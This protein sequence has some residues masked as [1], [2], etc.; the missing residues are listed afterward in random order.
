MTSLS[1]VTKDLKESL[2]VSCLRGHEAPV[3][4]AIFDPRGRYLATTSCD[5]SMRV[6][7]LENGNVRTQELNTVL[8][9]GP[10]VQ[11]CVKQL[12]VLHKCNDV[13]LAKSLATV[14]WQPPHGKVHREAIAM[15]LNL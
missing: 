15:L 10:C 1:K 7:D 9:A 2:Q 14:S 11:V 4:C 5:G 12:Q 13:S 8:N 6:W 3:L